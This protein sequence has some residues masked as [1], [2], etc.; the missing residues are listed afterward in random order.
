MEG[1]FF[2]LIVGLIFLAIN[3][4]RKQVEKA[5]KQVRNKEYKNKKIKI[6]NEKKEEMK[7]AFENQEVEMANKFNKICQETIYENR[8]AL[9]TERQKYLTKDSYGRTIDMGWESDKNLRGDKNTAIDYFWFTI[10]K[11]ELSNAFKKIDYPKTIFNSLGEEIEF[12]NGLDWAGYC[13]VTKKLNKVIRRGYSYIPSVI[14]WTVEEIN[15]VCDEIQEKNSQ[16]GDTS[17]MNGVEFEE[18]CKRILEDAGWEVEDTPTSGD[19]GVDLIASI[20]DARVCIQCKCF[21]KA[22]GNK[23]VQEVAAGMIHWKG[24]HAVVVA[25]SGF[26]KSAKSLATSNKVILTSDSELENLENLVL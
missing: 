21:A 10:L 4:G 15:K 2:L 6:F 25:K 8:Y 1:F 22:V 5:K 11:E 19:Q 3:L 7:K 16:F 14:Y 24:T 18:Y 17:S 13:F 12:Y 20:E 9:Q 26:T 23:A